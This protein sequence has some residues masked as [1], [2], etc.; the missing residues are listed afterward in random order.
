MVSLIV[1]LVLG[2]ATMVF[3]VKANPSIFARYSSGTATNSSE[4]L[5]NPRSDTERRPTVQV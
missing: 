4:R 1:H 2:F 3:T 5:C